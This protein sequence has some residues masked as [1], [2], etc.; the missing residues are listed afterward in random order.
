V[1]IASCR[2]A[3]AKARLVAG[4]Y[5]LQARACRMLDEASDHT[6]MLAGSPLYTAPERLRG[7]KPEPASD[8]FSVGATLFTALE[9]KSPFSGC[10]LFEITVAVVEGKPAP[11]MH[12]GLLRPVIEGLLANHPAD[13]L[14]GQ[15]AHR[16]LLDI[17]QRLRPSRAEV[18]EGA[19]N[20]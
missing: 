11:C 13:R 3:S 1:R 19:V 4:R 6:Q 14:T 2:P 17:Q 20:A 12:A 7:G 9:G 15:R 5:R 8:M 16:A 18:V 10:S